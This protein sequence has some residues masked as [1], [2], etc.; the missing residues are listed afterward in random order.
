ML[1][2]GFITSTRKYSLQVD[3]K[4]VKTWFA[5]FGTLGYAAGM[6]MFFVFVREFFRYMTLMIDQEYLLVLSPKETTFYNFFYAFLATLTSMSFGVETFVKTQFQIPRYV[7]YSISND[8]G[9]L[10]WLTNYFIARVAIFMGL[11]AAVI[12]VYVSFDFYKDYWFLFPLILIVLFLNQ[13]TRFRYFIRTNSLRVMVI[14]FVLTIIYSSFLTALPVFDAEVFNRY[15]LGKTV[16]YNYSIKLPDSNYRTQIRR[17]SSVQDI[18]LGY[19][20]Y[21]RK[22]SAVIVVKGIAKPIT[23]FDLTRVLNN[24]KER[25]TFLDQYNLLIALSCDKNVPMGLVKT[26]LEILREER[27]K[28]VIFMTS[29]FQSGISLRLVPLCFEVKMDTTSWQPS[30]ADLN[31]EMKKSNAFKVS[32]VDDSIFLNKNQSSLKELSKQLRAWANQHKGD[33]FID[34]EVDNKSA[35]GSFISV[36]DS[37]FQTIISLRKKYAIEHFSKKY[38]DINTIY[39]DRQLY[40]T[41]L[42]VYP[43]SLVL[44]SDDE[45]KFINSLK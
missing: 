12:P 21:G 25:V 1:S 28:S 33:Y 18:F 19:P 35:Y 23:K 43:V 31:K 17:S 6:Y 4:N 30:C 37:T 39:E 3:W 45:R 13:W 44:L 2:K 40:D 9:G 15:V 27:M 11:F 10:I 34:M 26:T 36:L 24:S 5:I 14:F 38:D 29:K 20:K 16:G 7:R 32:L 22:D 8:F 42:R 41:L